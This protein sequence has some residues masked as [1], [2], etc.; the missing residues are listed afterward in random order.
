MDDDYNDLIQASSHYRAP[1]LSVVRFLKNI[2]WPRVEQI[3]LDKELSVLEVGPGISSLF[4]DTE[5]SNL[6]FQ[7]VSEVQSLDINPK[8]VEFMQNQQLPLGY[9]QVFRELD[10]T[11][12]AWLHCFE[13]VLDHSCF[14]CLTQKSLQQRYLSQVRRALVPGGIYF[15][16]SMVKPKKLSLEEGHELDESTGVL[17]RDGRPWRR[18]VE[19]FEVEKMLKD[20][21]LEIEFFKV[22]ENEKAVL[23]KERPIPMSSDPDILR[24]I[25]RAPV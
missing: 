14:H 17:T 25:A 6:A 15:L 22:L 4:A 5:L 23:S 10:V 13:L 9:R 12:E 20:A 19:A 3:F 2:L 7:R 18:L 24:V 16:Q 11:Q 8:V 1:D 21:G